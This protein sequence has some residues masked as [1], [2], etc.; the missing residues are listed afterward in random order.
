[1]LVQPGQAL[2]GLEV[3]LDRPPEP[4]DLDQRGQ[5]DVPGCVAPV[6]GQFA[7]APVAADQQPVVPGLAGV[8]SD[9]GS[10]VVAVAFGTRTGGVPLP[11]RPGQLAGEFVGAAGAQAGGEPVAAGHVYRFKTIAGCLTL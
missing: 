5:R 4:G 10:V 9:P 11:R 3:L 6:V 7:G 1:M 2:A 8:G